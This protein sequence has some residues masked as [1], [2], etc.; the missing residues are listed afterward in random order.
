MSL[1][2]FDVISTMSLTE[3]SKSIPQNLDYSERN[4]ILPKNDTQK[5]GNSQKMIPKNPK[6][7]QKDTQK[8]GSNPQKS[9]EN[10]GTSLY[11]DIYKLP[12]PLGSA[13]SS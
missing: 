13:V 11:N 4:K 3:I 7:A 1:I 10:N 9:T 6:I 5:S 12:P 8:S 2:S